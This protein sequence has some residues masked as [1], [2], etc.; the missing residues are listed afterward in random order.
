MLL[1][2]P[3]QMINGVN[4]MSENLQKLYMNTTTTTTTTNNNNNNN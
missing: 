4:I 1:E 3:S 2:N